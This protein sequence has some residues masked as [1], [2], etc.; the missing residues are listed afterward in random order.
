MC[1]RYSLVADQKV[2]ENRYNARFPKETTVRYNVAPTQKMSI[3][4]N[5]KESEGDFW[6]WGLIP[7]W[8]IND[9][10]GA[11]LIN[12][13]SENL[14]SKNTFKNLVQS[15]R[16]L[17][18]ADGFYEWKKELKSR[19]PY[20]FTLPDESIFSFAGIWDEWQYEDGSKIGTFG[21]I[22][23]EAIGE[24]KD[25]HDRM[26]VILNRDA[27]KIWLHALLSEN[28]IKDIFAKHSITQLNHYKA[29]RSVNSSSIDS[30]ECIAIAPKIYPGET[31]SLFD[32]NS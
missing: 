9:A 23:R 3:L 20:R 14:F 24:I 29:H 32:F 16:C 26:P 22:T 10:A 30:P 31:Y 17:I 2:L 27:E 4:R 8:S 18:P 25:I 6:K 15:Q 1:G 28:D 12:I 7:S 19:I 21:I 5:N 11:N 13:R